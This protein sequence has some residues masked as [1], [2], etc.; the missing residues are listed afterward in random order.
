MVSMVRQ[1]V[2]SASFL[3]TQKQKEWLTC[4]RVIQ[5]DFKRLEKWADRN[6]MQFNMKCKVLH[7]GRSNPRYEYI[8]GATHL[9]IRFAEKAL[10]VLVDTK[11]NVSQQRAF[12]V[13][14]S[15]GILGCITQSIASR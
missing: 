4:Q 1:S 13:K 3:I 5:R 11:L 15:N 12:S 8:L 14:K 2:P 7:L 10:V 9:E 6:L